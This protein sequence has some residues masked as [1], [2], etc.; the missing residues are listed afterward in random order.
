MKLE[1]RLRQLMPYICQIAPIPTLE[2]SSP[3]TQQDSIPQAAD[4]IFVTAESLREQRPQRGIQ[5]FLFAR[6]ATFPAS[7][8]RCMIL[9]SPRKSQINVPLRFLEILGGCP[10]LIIELIDVVLLQPALLTIAIFAAT[11]VA[12]VGTTHCT[13]NVVTSVRFTSH[14]RTLGTRPPAFAIAKLFH[15][16]IF[17]V[18]AAW[19]T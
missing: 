16:F 13:Q 3:H 10:Y 9:L 2:L 17:G 15:F 4:T 8:S 11:S 1:Q 7:Y 5:P 18:A 6:A 14:G 12:P 19:F